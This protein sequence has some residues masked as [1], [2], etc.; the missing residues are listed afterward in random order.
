MVCPQPYIHP[1]SNGPTPSQIHTEA[2]CRNRHFYMVTKRWV[3][4]PSRP[5]QSPVKGVE[6]LGNVNIVG[7]LQPICTVPLKVNGWEQTVYTLI[8][9]PQMF[10]IPP[11]TVWESSALADLPC[12]PPCIYES[13][14]IEPSRNPCCSHYFDCI[15][16]THRPFLVEIVVS[17]LACLFFQAN[18]AWS[19]WA[20]TTGQPT[21]SVMV[22][23]WLFMSQ[24][25]YQWLQS[26]QISIFFIHT[27]LFIYEHFSSQGSPISPSKRT[28]TVFP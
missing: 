10:G 26:E 1:I 5:Q 14:F 2:M 8:S 18:G 27:Q 7:A 15:R 24:V 6:G 11:V 21:G 9:F 28:S 3:V 13:T 23:H 20:V 25:N 4:Y 12:L 16:H 19:V 17:G 22:S